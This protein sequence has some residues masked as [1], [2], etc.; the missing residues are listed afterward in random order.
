VPGC[1]KPASGGTA[2]KIGIVRKA[3]LA[4]EKCYAKAVGGAGVLP[5]GC[6]ANAETKFA[7]AWPKTEAPGNDSLTIGDQLIVAG[8]VDQLVSD[9]TIQ[10]G[11]ITPASKCTGKQY[12]IAAK[13]VGAAANCQ[14]KAIKKGIAPDARCQSKASVKFGAAWAKAEAPGH[15]CLTSGNVGS[16]GALLDRALATMR[17]Q[18]VP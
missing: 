4:K 5:V 14:A 9:L 7:A 12:G 17:N 16:V 8:L 11:G 3:I 1:S 6:I 15:D 13:R 10:L 2:K 18:L